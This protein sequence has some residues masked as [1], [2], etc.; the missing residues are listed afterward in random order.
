[1]RSATPRKIIV[2]YRDNSGFAPV[3]EW[4][5]ELRRPL[6]DLPR[7]DIYELRIRV[8]RVNYRIRY[9]FH[10]RK[11]SVA[12]QARS[13]EDRVPATE[14]DGSIRLKREFAADREKHSFTAEE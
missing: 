12:A 7:D 6:A 3:F 9:F 5:R 1:M 2:F 4:L 10:G 11:L 14:I 8:G 13:K